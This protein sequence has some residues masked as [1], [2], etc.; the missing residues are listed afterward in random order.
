MAIPLRSI[1]GQATDLRNPVYIALDPSGNIYAA[2]S[3]YITV[4]APGSDGNAPPIRSFRGKKTG[5]GFSGERGIAVDSEG[6]IYV[7]T[8]HGCTVFRQCG[9]K[10]QVLVFPPDANGKVTPIRIIRGRKTGLGSPGAVAVDGAGNVYVLGESKVQNILVYAAGASGD[11][12]PIQ[13]IT[14]SKTKIYGADGIAV[15]AGGNIYVANTYAP[16]GKITV[17]AAGATGNVAP[18][19]TIV[20]KRTGL[21]LPFGIAVH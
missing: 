2:D 20:G 6:Y 5:M 4:Y 15:D 8:S 12:A 9:G 1:Y 18:I 11:V 10:N 19:R 21:E 16:K 3:G 17:Y 13:D 14:G 7:T